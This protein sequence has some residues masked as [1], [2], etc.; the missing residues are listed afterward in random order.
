ML[1]FRSV[2]YWPVSVA[3]YWCCA[4]WFLYRVFP[5]F[6]DGAGGVVSFYWGHRPLS[7]RSADLLGPLRVRAHFLYQ[8]WVAAAVITLVGF[9]VIASL[10]GDWR[11]KYSRTFWLSSA[12]TLVGLLLVVAVS[13]LG[14]ALNL[15]RGPEM[16]NQMH[17]VFA[18]LKLLVPMS[19]LT[20]IMALA[21]GSL[22]A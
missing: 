17:N 19:L 20:G 10:P 13:D 14:T 15:W 3:L 6:V 11:R 18:F 7:V 12:M 2:L 8:Y 22:K 5:I 9:A 21:R 4:C 1:R 16:Y